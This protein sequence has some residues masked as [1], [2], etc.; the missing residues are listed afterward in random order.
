MTLA[1]QKPVSGLT[2]QR[3]E[4]TSKQILKEIAQAQKTTKITRYGAYGAL[5]AA[6]YVLYRQLIG[7][8]GR[9]QPLPAMP[10]LINLPLNAQDSYQALQDINRGVAQANA[11]INRIMY[12]GDIPAADQGYIQGFFSGAYSI[13]K[14]AMWLTVLGVVMLGLHTGL[15]GLKSLMSASKPYRSFSDFVRHEEFFQYCKDLTDRAKEIQAMPLIA[16]EELSGFMYMT[17]GLINKKLARLCGYLLTRVNQHEHVNPGLAEQYK[18]VIASFVSRSQMLTEKL[19]LNTGISESAQ[20]VA[21]F[22][23]VVESIIK[24]AMHIEAMATL[25]EV[26]I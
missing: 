1:A 8:N 2:K 19:F 9:P 5:T 15:E 18:N 7:G 4:S 16:Q 17:K 14:H 25:H 20:A 26:R 10:H 22:I 12:N 6:A 11:N 21:E 23:G 3:I 13:G 24:Q